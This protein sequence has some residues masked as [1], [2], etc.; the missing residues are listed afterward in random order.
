MGGWDKP[1]GQGAGRI[2]HH[3][4]RLVGHLDQGGGLLGHQRIAGYDDGDAIAKVTHMV[5][6]QAAVFHIPLG[7]IEDQ[8]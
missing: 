4:Q 8:A 6:E 3:R 1:L 5:G 7:L 2:R